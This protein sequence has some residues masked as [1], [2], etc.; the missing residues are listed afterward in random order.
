MK[1]TRMFFLLLSLAIVVNKMQSQ[2]IIDHATARA[3]YQFSYKTKADLDTYDK[4]DL[5][6]LDVGQKTSKFYSRYTQIRDSVTA[7]EL[8][9]GF[10]VAEITQ[11]RKGLKKGTNI[12]YYQDFSLNTTHVVS[13]L[14]TYGFI[15]DEKMEL[16]KW[17]ISNEKI[18]I[19]G[20]SCQK[21]TTSFLGREWTA[22]FTPEI[23][24]NKGPWK[25][26]GLQGLIVQASDNQNIFEYKLTG[27]ELIKK[28]TP[29]VYTHTRNNGSEYKKTNKKTV[30]DYE[31]KFYDDYF[32]FIELITGSKPIREGGL[33]MPKKSVEYIPLEP[34]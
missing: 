11:S 14:A 13:V 27:F 30:F 6:Y 10:S 25:L 26:W 4:T 34:W 22:Y 19:N 18:E 15:Y 5:M 20:Y 3:S 29:I 2:E 24:M 31:K 33:P 9:K 7:D 16:P 28:Q 8:K 23:A 12:V 1:R 21:A 17:V 32:S